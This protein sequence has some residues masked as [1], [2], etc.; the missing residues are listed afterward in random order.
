MDYS[1]WFYIFFILFVGGAPDL[2]N[3]T[4]GRYKHHFNGCVRVVEGES[5]GIIELGKV[6]VSGINVDTCPE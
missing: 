2:D 6:A 5:S 4:G 3:F 1:R